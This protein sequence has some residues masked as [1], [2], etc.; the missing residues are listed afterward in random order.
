VLVD[1][2]VQASG[3]QTSSKNGRLLAWREIDLDAVRHNVRRIAETCPSAQL[4]VVVKADGYSHGAPEV[5]RAALA[6]GA[7]YLG[8]ATLGEALALRRAGITAPVLAWLAGP[9]SPYGTAI[10]QDIELAAYSCAQLSEI[11]QVAQ[12]QGQVA[13]VHLK[14]ETGMWRGGAADE[15]ALLVAQARDHEAQGLVRVVGVWSHLACA[16]RVDH[17]ANDEQRVRFLRAV[18]VA[19]D[20]GLRPR[21]RHLANSAA[22]LTR[23]DL[24]F[25]MVRCGLATYGVNPLSGQEAP[26]QLRPV[27]TV[28][29]RVTH[30]KRAPAGVGVSYGHTYRTPAPTTLA[31]VPL[32]YADGIPV[33][34]LEGAPVGYLGKSVPLAGRVC[35][36]QLVL[37]VGD[38]PVQPG[39]VVTLLG[40]GRDGEHRAEDWAALSGRSPYEIL[41]G[42]GRPRV[43]ALY[44]NGE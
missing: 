22:T 2:S 42:L 41:T 18:Q 37:D 40:P 16:D 26:V 44:V 13:R 31:L 15:W 9:G 29:A 30:V 34:P 8:V 20:A 6:A 19:E 36:D 3:K 1:S 7:T 4:M 24:H 11:V 10:A 32:G 17:P 43:P 5:A 35:M 21:L 28:K 39:D 14:A 38:M 12:E 25:D 23:P 27:V 33:V